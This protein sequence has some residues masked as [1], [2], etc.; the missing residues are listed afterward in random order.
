M[1]ENSL[2]NKEIIIESLT[3]IDRKLFGERGIDAKIDGKWYT[4]DSMKELWTR[5]LDIL[6][7]DKSG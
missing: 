7:D 1:S 6:G 4:F 3:V 2:D 5:Y